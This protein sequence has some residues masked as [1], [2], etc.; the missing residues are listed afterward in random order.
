MRQARTSVARRAAPAVTDVAEAVEHLPAADAP[1][2]AQT[3]DASADVASGAPA[4]SGVIRVGYAPIVRVDAPRREIELCATSEAIDSYGTVFDYAASKDAFTRWIGNVR[5]MH[6]QRAVGRRVAVRCDDDAR[7]IYVRLRVSKGAEDTWEK[8]ADGT[9][10]GASFGASNVTWQRQVRRLGGRD[11]LLDVATRYDLVELSL[12]DNPSNPDALGITVV[13]DAAPDP[14][15]LDRLDRPDEPPDTHAQPEMS[16]VEDAR[17]E[18]AAADAAPIAMQA[19]RPATARAALLPLSRAARDDA[20]GDEPR[21]NGESEGSDDPWYR[22]LVL[23]GLGFARALGPFSTNPEGHPDVG[24]PTRAP[25]RP[26]SALGVSLDGNARERF[27]DAARGILEGCGCPLCE[28]A[29]AALGEMG[30]AV[31]ATAVGEPAE[32][33]AASMAALRDG[34]LARALAAG[35]SASATRIER[36]DTSVQDLR[37]AFEDVMRRLAGSVGDLYTRLER[38]EAQPAPGGPVAPA[39]EKTHALAAAGA[40]PV[41]QIS[42]AE[43]YRALESLAGKLSDPQAQIAVAAELIRLQQQQGR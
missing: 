41:G 31:E 32:R 13:R 17:G 5:E 24:V 38:V 35:L 42:A 10:R 6:A 33:S 11:R 34:A 9:L 20:A 25:E 8:I 1:V 28:G 30:G 14:A 43:Q 16:A 18:P 40:S 22:Q 27:H 4:G 29:I 2:D 36:M 21:A 26:T 7:K 3:G 23:P 37:A 39:V 12:V 15:L 19:E